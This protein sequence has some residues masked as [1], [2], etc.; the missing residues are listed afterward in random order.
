M[1]TPGNLT[2]CKVPMCSGMPPRAD[3]N[4]VLAV[5]S[6]MTRCSC[7]AEMP[8][9]FGARTC[10]NAG[11][12]TVKSN[13]RDTRHSCFTVSLQILGDAENY[14]DV[15]ELRRFPQKTQTPW[16]PAVTISCTPSLFRS[17]TANCDP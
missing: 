13:V 4:A 7:A 12:T 5:S 3:Q 2:P 6:V 17:A 14:R 9:A 10:A 11:E 1:Y 8:A 16:S 15:E